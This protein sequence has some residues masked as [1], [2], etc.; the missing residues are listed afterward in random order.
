MKRILSLVALA[1]IAGAAHA[2]RTLRVPSQYSTIPGALAV[3][4]DYDT[5]LVAAGTYGRVVIDRLTITLRS[6]SGYAMTT[7]RGGL[8]F[9]NG[10]SS[11]VEG[12][13]IT[14]STKSGVY[15]GGAS[16]TVRDC[17]IQGNAGYSFQTGTFTVDWYAYGGGVYSTGGGQ[18]IRCQIVSNGASAVGQSGGSGTASGGGVY[19]FGGTVLRDCSVAN[20]SA[21]ARGHFTTILGNASGG[22]VVGATCI[23]TLILRNTA[24]GD[25]TSDGG[26]AYLSTCINCNILANRVHN[27]HTSAGTARSTLTN[28]IVRGNTPT[29]G[30]ADGTFQHCNVEGGAPG[31]G[32]F[33]LDPMFVTGG[34]RLAWNSPCRDRG[35]AAGLPTHDFEG[36]PRIADGTVDVG[37]DEFFVGQYVKG[38]A[39]P[40]GAITVTIHGDPGARTYLALSTG[41]WTP[42]WTIPGFQGTLSVRLNPAGILDLGTLDAAGRTSFRINIP[43]PFPV[44]TFTLQSLM[45]NQLSLPNTVTVQ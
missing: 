30:Q 31:A 37:L 3:A 20:N 7:I 8:E 13:T 11:V 18:F 10:G 28:C 35:I 39:R 24:D 21:Y 43:R 15:I 26:G 19:S 29:Q 6:E 36:H 23:N 4:N 9:K 40:G 42:P 5:I 34:Q 25:K 2:Q 1:A 32:N 22:G 12:F 41:A 45:R 38:N 17:L 44:T 14:R 27:R 33:D 16:P